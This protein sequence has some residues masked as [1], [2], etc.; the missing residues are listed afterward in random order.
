M[1]FYC[2]ETMKWCYNEMFISEIHTI[3]YYEHQSS[4]L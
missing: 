2:E 3:H 1:I 4:G